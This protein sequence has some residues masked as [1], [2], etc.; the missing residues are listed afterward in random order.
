[1]RQQP[2]RALRAAPR[3]FFDIIPYAGIQWQFFVTQVVVAPE[4]SD[5]PFF[6]RPQPETIKNRR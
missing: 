5:V 4:Y 2:D 1:M 6:Y 3:L